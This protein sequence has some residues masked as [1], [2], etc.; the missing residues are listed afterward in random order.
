M[1]ICKF[2]G[3]PTN[4]REIGLNKRYWVCKE[5]DKNRCKDCGCFLHFRDSIDG[6]CMECFNDR[7][8][9]FEKKMKGGE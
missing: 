2:C 5:C 9:D 6:L 1:N 7:K 4:Y 8:I 3:K